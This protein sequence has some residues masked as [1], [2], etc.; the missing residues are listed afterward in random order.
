[1]RASTHIA[2]E[3]PGNAVTRAGVEG[4]GSWIT[5]HDIQHPYGIPQA[6]R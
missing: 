5:S 6:V 4:F 3:N 2:K 1:M